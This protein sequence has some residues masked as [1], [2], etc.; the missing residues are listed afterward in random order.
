MHTVSHHL[1]A[2]SLC[3]RISLKSNG[4]LLF[5]EFLIKLKVGGAHVPLGLSVDTPLHVSFYALKNARYYH[6]VNHS[7][8]IKPPIAKFEHI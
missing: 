2:S 8:F 5:N 4:L 7:K 3:L 6:T 1:D